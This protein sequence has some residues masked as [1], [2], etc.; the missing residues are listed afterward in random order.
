MCRWVAYAGKQIYLEDLLFHQEHSIVKQSLAANQSSWVT[1]GDG[2]GV[3]WFGDKKTPG[4]FKDILPAWN[5]SN[6]RSL[7]AHIK[8]SLFFAHVRA[9]TGTSVSR[10]NCHPFVWGNWVF[11]HNGKIGNWHDC[12]KDVEDLIDHSHYP[13][14]E[15]TTDSEAL[16]LAALSAGLT[17]DPV[18]VF[19][20]TFADIEKIMQKN[21]ATEP[22]RVSCALT[23]GTE[24]WSIRYSSD[25][26]SPSM[27][28]GSPHTRAHETGSN[29]INTIASEPS[30]S[31]ASH[32]FKV[33][34]SSGLH[35]S[36]KGIEEFSF[37]I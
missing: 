8:T 25:H 37:Q 10:N 29:P 12:R 33:N 3:A 32:W 35:W 22:L 14:R 11:M 4:I 15:G 16:F 36:P 26:Q 6:L 21:N 24:M 23:N 13:F 1:N 9:T 7:A 20:K 19:K 18:G 2:F 34:E 30:D 31:D 5:D 17:R 27:Y 28:F